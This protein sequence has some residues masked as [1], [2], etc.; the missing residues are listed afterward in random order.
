MKNDKQKQQDLVKA[1]RLLYEGGVKNLLVNFFTKWE[2]LLVIIFIIMFIVFGN[3]NPKFLKPSNLLDQTGTFAEKAIVALPM[4]FIIMCGDIDISVA[5]IIAL[6]AFS[7]GIAAEQGAGTFSLV[8]IGLVV[9]FACGFLNGFF[10]TVF[11]MPAIA[12]TLATQSIYRGISKGVLQEHACTTFP[13]SFSVFGQ[14][15]LGNST[16]PTQLG[17]YIVLAIIMYIVLHHTKYGRRLYA[18]G[19]CAEAA[20]FSGIK[21]KRARII[22]FSL[23][24]LFCGIAAVVLASRI[25]SVRSNIAEG[26]D[27]E[28]I[29][30]VVLG[31][32]SITGGKGN[33]YGVVISSFLVGYMKFGLT[34]LRV[35]GTYQTIAVGLL[36]IVAVLLPRLLDV[37]KANRKL[38]KQQAASRLDAEAMNL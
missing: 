15:Y 6:S 32:V 33:L 38:A 5:S 23:T 26:Y 13:A 20:R 36:L 22:N 18:I 1:S 14:G 3:L 12:V 30:L 8:L 17:I 28:I 35:S 31:G 19:N 37:F 7:M 2:V 16:I 9:G 4:I 10:I 21:V 24:G 27:M 29:T 11:D 25:G 34:M